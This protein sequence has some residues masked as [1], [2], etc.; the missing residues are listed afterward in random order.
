MPDRYCLDANSPAHGFMD[1]FLL[2]NGHLGATLRSGVGEERID[3]NLDRFWSG[4]PLLAPEGASPAEL[5]PDLR[6][7]IRQRDGARADQLSMQMQ[8]K[9]WTQAYQPLAAL[10]WNFASTAA[11]D[12]VA[13]YRRR[14][15]LSTATAE[16]SYVGDGGDVRI[17]SFV[18]GP[19]DVVAALATGQALLPLAKMGLTW[20]CQ[21]P[22]TTREWAESGVRWVLVQGRA[23]ACVIPPYI[24]SD[25]PIVYGAEPPAQDGT[26]AAGMGFCVIAALAPLAKGGVRL[27]IAAECGFRGPFSRPSAD[28]DAMA[29]RAQ[30]RLQNA[31]AMDARDL[32][33]ASTADH[34]RYFD[35]NDLRLPSRPDLGAED[36][37][38]AEL[39]YHFGRY[40]LICSS[41]NGTEPPN[42]Q[43]IWNPYMRPAWS[44]NHTTNINTPMIY[45]PSEPTGLGDLAAPFLDMVSELVRAGR[46]SARHYYGAP[47]SVV[48]HNT[49][50]WRFTEPVEGTP[51]WANWTSALP[52]FLAQCWDHWDYGSGDDDFAA[53]QLLPMMAEVAQFALFML[54]EDEEGRLVVSPSSSPEH[55]YL[56]REDAPRGVTE[57][58]ALDQQ[59]YAQLLRRLVRLMRHFGRQ[60]DL[61]RRA[62]D[63]LR[64]LRDTDI[65]PEGAAREWASMPVGAEPGHRH[66]SHLYAIYPGEDIPEGADANKALA[67][68]RALDDRLRHGTGH[69]GWSQA[70]VLC[71][72]ARFGDS[73]LAGAAV[74]NLVGDLTTRT[75]LVLH[76]YEASPDKA[77]FQIDGNFGATAG[78]LETLMQSRDG[79]TVLLAA[80]PETW[81]HGR[82]S[83]AI[84]R[85][86]HRIGLQWDNL[87]L[88]C[89]SIEARK[90]DMVTLDIALGN[91]YDVLRVS[92]GSLCDVRRSEDTRLGRQQ[93]VWSISVGETYQVRPEGA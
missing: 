82:L 36:P 56:D 54:V 5:L 37:A 75:L 88:S 41:R 52:W 30:A 28:V 63:A 4:G 7:A 90:D 73:V 68:R 26:V 9:G 32:H 43:G 17:E 93:L 15:N 35:R 92:D 16:Q 86:G 62:E 58:A 66:L 59:L 13:N 21:H 65:G 78:I 23:P 60:D 6:R 42:L 47:G 76:P 51:V 67:F 24:Q 34:R 18:S 8:G 1:S 85:G 39:L 70:W 38:K 2:G 80:L 3:I 81:T 72:A 12:Q 45:W 27:L 14:L 33:Q 71:L 53:N 91:S 55:E 49:D 89:A 40:L 44:S 46:K 31:L 20:D 19:Q 57:G 25:Q 50:V 84:L 83:G 61:T 87:R 74:K 77:V 79:K 48:H 11:P 64:R 29:E 10:R 22:C 69:T